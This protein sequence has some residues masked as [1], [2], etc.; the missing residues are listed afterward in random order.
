MKNEM[1]VRTLSAR[2]QRKYNRMMEKINAENEKL[3]GERTAMSKIINV[4]L[5]GEKISVKDAWRLTGT[6][7]LRSYITRIRRRGYNVK[8]AYLSDNNYKHYWIED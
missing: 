8:S 3:Y 7:E 4:L 1:K 2:Q 5:S 6:S